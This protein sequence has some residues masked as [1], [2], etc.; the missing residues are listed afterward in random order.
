VQ[1]PVAV[2]APAVVL[3]EWARQAND[4]VIDPKES[5]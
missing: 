3:I 4:S 2:V 5:A 1:V